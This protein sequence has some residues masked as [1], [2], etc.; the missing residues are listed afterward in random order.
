METIQEQTDTERIPLGWTFSAI[1]KEC[2]R[3]PLNFGTASL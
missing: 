3:Q 2:H 1:P